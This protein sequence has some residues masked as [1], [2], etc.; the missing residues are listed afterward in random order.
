MKVLHV[1]E[2]LG[3]G[4]SEQVLVTLLPELVRQGCQAEV[5]VCRPSYDLQAELAQHGIEVHRL[6]LRKKW[7][8]LGQAR[9]IA[10]LAGVINAD[11]VHAHLYFPAVATAFMRNLRL[12]RVRTCVTFHNLAYA[13]ANKTWLGLLV[14]KRLAALLYPR[15]FDRMFA[16][17]QAVGTHYQAALGLSGVEVCFNPV[18]MPAVRSAT[19]PQ[20]VPR[21][22]FPGR[23]VPE[24]GHQSLIA[25]LSLLKTPVNVTF[26]GG[27]PLTQELAN[28]A[29]DVRITG[30]LPHDEMLT[31]IAQADLVVIPSTHE[32]FGLTALE[33][34]A[35]G[36]PV[37][38]T[39]AG[40]LPEVLGDTGL[41]V[42]VGD[43]AALAQAIQGLLDDPERCISM[44]RAGR[45]R[46]Q[47]Q[48]S[49][50]AIAAQLL[51]R[52]HDALKGRPA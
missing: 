36:R 27:G 39:R 34:M 35:L 41:L 24:K 7:N 11:V 23:L 1:I 50:P 2:S 15:G 45:E 30:P 44:G 38:A 3:R 46:A 20:S 6:P 51:A 9:A 48:F 22:T 13:G 14:K 12:S 21:I 19:Q 43:S 26:A 28:A 47:G 4:G 52:Y 33:A 17:S 49:P 10:R 42:P 40:G 8:L 32:G 5:A 25:A 16:V 37:I 18:E 31:E 29:P